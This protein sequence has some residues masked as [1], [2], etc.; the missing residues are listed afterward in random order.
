LPLSRVCAAAAG[1][2]LV[3]TIVAIGITVANR[4]LTHEAAARQ[5]A[6]NQAVMWGQIDQRLANSLGTIAA[7][8]NDARIRKLLDEHGISLPA[9]PAAPMVATPAPSKPK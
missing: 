2:T 7:R 3:I 8:D 1:L 5:Q 9:Q 6:I 4:S